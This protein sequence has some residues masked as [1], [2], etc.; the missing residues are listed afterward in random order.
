MSACWNSFI[1]ATTWDSTDL[2]M[3]LENEDR[4]FK[5]LHQYRL[6]TKDSQYLWPLSR[7]F[8]I[9]QLN[10][11]NN[12]KCISN[13]FERNYWKLFEHW[14]WCITDDKWLYFRNYLG[15]DCVYLFDSHRKDYEGN[16]SQNG[17]AVLMKF[18]NLDDLQD[19]IKLIYYSSQHHKTL[20]FQMQIISI[21]C[22]NNLRESIKSE[23]ILNRPKQCITKKRKLENSQAPE[24]LSAKKQKNHTLNKFISETGSFVGRTIHI[25]KIVQCTHNQEDICYG[26]TAGIQCL[27]ISLMA[28]CW[29]LIK[30]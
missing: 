4:L 13:F 12:I 6:L 7:Y 11:W 10:W 15:K 9:R 27:C 19:Y 20:Y 1:S 26:S 3:I 25:Q 16:I 21:R 18:E 30:S 22:S 5:S 17:S 2:D 29:S 28:V 24:M 14:K 8:F 23:L